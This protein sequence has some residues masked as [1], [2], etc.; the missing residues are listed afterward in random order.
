VDLYPGVECPGP[1]GGLRMSSRQSSRCLTMASARGRDAS[2]DRCTPLRGRSRVLM[3]PAPCSAARIMSLSAVV[4]RSV[5]G[6]EDEAARRSYPPA[7]RRG[8]VQ[9]RDAARAAPHGRIVDHP[10]DG[11]DQRYRRLAGPYQRTHEPDLRAPRPALSP[12]DFRRDRAPPHRWFTANGG[13]LAISD[14]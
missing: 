3:P 11:R 9:A 1:G 13:K 4:A 6:G 5:A 10:G 8:Q 12:A 2:M 14:R 7:P